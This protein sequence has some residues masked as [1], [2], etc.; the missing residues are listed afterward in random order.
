[1]SPASA[2]DG[3]DHSK[4]QTTQVTAKPNSSIRTA[5][6]NVQTA[7]GQF[8]VLMRQSPTDPRAG[9]EVQF[10]AN[11]SERVEGGFSG[12]EPPPVTGANVSARITTAAGQVIADKLPTHP[13]GEGAYGVHYK[14]RS[15]GDYKVVFDVRTSDG[16]PLAV[17]F[18]V[19]IVG[20]PVNWAFWLGLAALTLVSAGTIVGYYSSWASDGVR[21]RAGLR[22]TLPIAA[23]VVVFFLVGTVALAYFLPPRD[24][25]KTVDLQAASATVQA[26]GAAT[27][28]GDPSLGGSGAHI[29]ISK[30]SQLLFNIRTEPVTERQIT[31]GLKVTGA[32]RA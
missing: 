22:K 20:A 21:G 18:P 6:R 7:T 19:T 25:R 17:D 32:V 16:R 27:S 26:P 10:A 29:N 14:F 3:E 13:E 11:F 12:S 28:A 8:H 15:A 1:M 23:G 24:K 30:E 5:E 2:H 9:E 31:S 4:E